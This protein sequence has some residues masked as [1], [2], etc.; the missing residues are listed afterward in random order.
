M[1]PTALFAT[2]LLAAAVLSPIAAHAQKAERQR[3]VFQVSDNDP[4]KWNLALN[5][6][7]NVQ[8]DLG[9]DN[10]DIEIVAYGPGLNM[11]KANSKVAPRLAQALDSSI[12]L[13]ACENTM[14]KTKTTKADMYSGISYVKAGVTHIMKRQQEGWA[15]VRP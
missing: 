1:K 12:G 4:A 10:V 14:R 15:Y 9:K 2:L 3:V 13:M 11:L 8:A 5:N 6:A 7:Q